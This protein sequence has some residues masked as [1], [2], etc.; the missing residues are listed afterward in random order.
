MILSEQE[1]QRRRP[2]WD[3]LSELFLDNELD[4]AALQFV[5]RTLR[6]AG[7]D[8]GDWLAILRHEVAPVVGGN[9]LTVAGEWAGFDPAWLEQRI[10]A[11]ASGPS[12]EGRLA[13]WLIRADV[14]R[15]QAAWAA[16][17]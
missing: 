17:P 14:Q 2:V 7:Y 12:L 16:Q 13:L 11:R 5:V 15:L 10:L 1:L 8:A 6:A 4:E 9:L 3:A